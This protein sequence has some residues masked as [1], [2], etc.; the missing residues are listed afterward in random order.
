MR[1]K[2][3]IREGLNRNFERDPENNVPGIRFEISQFTAVLVKKNDLPIKV[4]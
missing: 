3:L 2:I 4:V 1:M